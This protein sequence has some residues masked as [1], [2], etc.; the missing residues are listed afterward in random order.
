MRRL[1][2]GTIWYPMGKYMFRRFVWALLALCLC[3]CNEDSENGGDPGEPN[4]EPGEPCVASCK[5]DVILN[6]CFEGV[7]VT[8]NCAIDRKICK[9]AACVTP[10]P[11]KKKCTKSACLL[12]TLYEC[13]DGAYEQRDCAADGLIC[14]DAHCI[15]KII[16]EKCDKS[17]CVNQET[18][19]LCTE[20]KSS[21]VSCAVQDMV[22]DKAECVDPSILCTA[23][24]C[25]NETVLNNCKNGRIDPY[26]CASEEKICKNARCVEPQPPVVCTESVCA[27]N[28][29]ELLECHSTSVTT[30]DCSEYNMVCDKGT[31]VSYTCKKDST[32]CKG[33][34]LLSCSS[35]SFDI[36]NCG[37]DNM[38]C[39]P[40][41]LQCVYECEPE[42]YPSV[43]FASDKGRACVDYHITDVTCEAGTKCSDGVCIP[44]PCAS[45]SEEQYCLD[46]QCL[47]A[48]PE[49]LIGMPCDCWGKDCYINIS[50]FEFKHIFKGFALLIIDPLIADDEVIQM[51]NF[52][53]ES[54]T[55]CEGLA[56]VVPEGMR[57]GCFRDGSLH[58]PQSVLT[59]MD[60]V[61]GILASVQ[62]NSELITKILPVVVNVLR[63]GMSFTSPNGY[64]MTG[65]LDFSAT[66]NKDPAKR[67]MDEHALEKSKDPSTPKLVDKINAGD[68]AT[69]L[70]ASTA[71]A[72]AEQP[73]CPA[74]SSLYSYTIDRT[75]EKLG[76]FDVGLD[77]CLRDCDT[78]ADCRKDYNCV[79]IPTSLEVVDGARPTH[80]ACFDKRNLDMLSEILNTARDTMGTDGE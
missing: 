61:P 10:E 53:S 9:D 38:I 47:D 75:I 15:E 49:N 57:V 51:P 41:K 13:K 29:V 32:E 77:L 78:D 42:W 44:D 21:E 28:G 72:A 6:T 19:S 46:G 11:T 76:H 35:G 5:S 79:D 39:N 20:G 16:E 70:A 66:I 12:D 74:G 36:V 17:T 27:D 1:S 48:A 45:C 33:D 37:R 62:V 24:A 54:I 18:L 25:A 65:T 58:F 60:K 68:H 8:K 26:D 43:C 80:K 4:P 69:V 14:K 50:G 40:D 73:Y 71:A 3:A 56:A 52:F 22:C 55:G 31:C 59:L 7:A 30:I 2:F 64:C 34:F 23:T 67:L 63:Q